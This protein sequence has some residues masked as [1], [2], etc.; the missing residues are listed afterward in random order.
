MVPHRYFKTFKGEVKD[1]ENVYQDECTFFVRYLDKN[2]VYDLSRFEKHL[3][4]KKLMNEKKVGYGR[5]MMVES[6]TLLKQGIALLN[7]DSFF[8]LKGKPALDSHYS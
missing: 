1:G 6:E 3:L 8:F 7:Q 4:N 5:I 2:V